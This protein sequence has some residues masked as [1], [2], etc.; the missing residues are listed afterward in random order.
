VTQVT[1]EI[2]A[3]S[4]QQVLDVGNE[5]MA[6][7][8]KLSVP[9][10]HVAS[11]L[12]SIDVAMSTLG[13]DAFG[14]RRLDANSEYS[15]VVSL[16]RLFNLIVLQDAVSGQASV[17][18]IGDGFR[19]SA[20][21]YEVSPSSSS[22]TTT[23]S[24][25]TVSAPLSPLESKLSVQPG[26]V[27][28]VGLNANHEEDGEVRLGVS[29]LSARFFTNNG[30]ELSSNPLL[31]VKRKPLVDTSYVLE[32]V[33][34]NN[35]PIV[36][37]D[38][39]ATSF[40]TRC[41]KGARKQTQQLCPNGLSITLSCDGKS[42]YEVTDY[43]PVYK[44]YPSCIRLDTLGDE[45]CSL[46]SFDSF[47]TT[48]SCNFSTSSKFS[49][50]DVTTAFNSAMYASAL[51]IEENR[52]PSHS[53]PIHF[54]DWEKFV[55]V[56]VAYQGYFIAAAALLFLVISWFSVKYIKQHWKKLKYQKMIGKHTSPGTKDKY[57]MSDLVS[58]KKLFISSLEIN[59]DSR[60]KVGLDIDDKRLNN[61]IYFTRDNYTKKLTKNQLLL[62]RD[63]CVLLAS[64][65]TKLDNI[66]AIFP[67][68]QYLEIFSKITLGEVSQYTSP[69]LS[70]SRRSPEGVSR[71][72]IPFGSPQVNLENIYQGNS[73]AH[74][75]EMSN[76]LLVGGGTIPANGGINDS[77]SGAK[78]STSLTNTFTRNKLSNPLTAKHNTNAIRTANRLKI[79]TNTGFSAM[80]SAVNAKSVAQNTSNAQLSPTTEPISDWGSPTAHSDD[81]DSVNSEISDLSTPSVFI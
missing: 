76:S 24:T 11:T 7:A 73:D 55:V 40:K 78:A 23:S 5:I 63:E 48:C 54:T 17:D 79:G 31:I 60:A 14:R 69:G 61:V 81:S 75:P 28:F 64:E 42:D 46:K 20:R 58:L 37:L 66:M 34:E 80:R 49:A 33:L 59:R 70:Y 13:V 32:V 1:A 43:C 67:P 38:E 50:A 77:T 21:V 56:V 65:N 62:L 53:E 36:Y 9:Y 19:T 16:V 25:L 27:S 12:E 15:A 18:A 51:V 41:Y 10:E 29:S 57:D 52:K 30:T 6:S 8:L 47:N 26:R 74:V 39:V 2:S 22:S 68:E 71:P 4:V 3:Q 45:D 72:P 35:A 44:S